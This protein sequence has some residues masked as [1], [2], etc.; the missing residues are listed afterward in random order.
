MGNSDKA[1]N[2]RDF[3]LFLPGGVCRQK[4]NNVPFVTIS[5]HKNYVNWWMRM[6][7]LLHQQIC[8][9]KTSWELELC[10]QQTQRRYSVAGCHFD[11]SD[12]FVL[13]CDSPGNIFSLENGTIVAVVAG[14]FC[15]LDQVDFQLRKSVAAGAFPVG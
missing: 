12:T 13:R 10:I 9:G 2:Q 14:G 3:C 8:G 7:I 1:S 15:K 6:E 5:F 4:N 11:S